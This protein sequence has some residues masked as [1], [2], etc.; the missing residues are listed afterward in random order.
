MFD[1]FI[2]NNMGHDLFRWKGLSKNG[3]RIIESM[4]GKTWMT[5]IQI[6]HYTGIPHKTV[7][8]KMA[9]M[10]KAGL[11]VSDSEKRGAYY[12]LVDRMDLNKAAEILGTAGT[13]KR[14]KERHKREREAYRIYRENIQNN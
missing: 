6:A 13:E 12:K 1:S 3:L 9:K 2:I 7:R 8:R 4:S 14:Q 5:V 11:A 10:K